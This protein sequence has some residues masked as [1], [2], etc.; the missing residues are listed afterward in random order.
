MGK[1]SP[2]H[3]VPTQVGSFVFPH[4]FPEDVD[5][6]CPSHTPSAVFK[7]E[8]ISLR[9]K[10]PRTLA[11]HRRGGGW[12]CSK[13]W[14]ATR[15]VGEESAVIWLLLGVWLCLRRVGVGKSPRKMRVPMFCELGTNLVFFL[16]Y[17]SQIIW[18]P[19]ILYMM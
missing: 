16:T 19:M 17:S 14:P 4:H 18:V 2:R 12:L 1:V 3:P 8:S 11:S 13:H 6:L 10:S 5:A 9:M 7:D 15:M